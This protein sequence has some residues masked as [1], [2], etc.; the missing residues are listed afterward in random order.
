MTVGIVDVEAGKAGYDAA[1]ACKMERDGGAAGEHGRGA[2]E[3]CCAGFMED[4]CCAC[5]RLF[6][7][8]NPMV[9]RYMYAFIF[10]VTNL[11]AWTARDY[12]NF[13]L[14]ELQRA[15]PLHIVPH[16]DN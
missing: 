10:L 14:A 5:A 15:C 1:A 2:E 9:A 4:W 7:G 11:L 12:G 16:T 6:L 8:P 13:A 3:R